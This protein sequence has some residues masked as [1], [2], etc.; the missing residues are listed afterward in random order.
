MKKEALYQVAWHNYSPED[1]IRKLGS[2]KSG[3]SNTEVRKRKHIYGKNQISE[4]KK[5]L[6]ILKFLKQ[7]NNP[8]IYILLVAMII[9]LVFGHHIDAYV[10]FAVMMI[11]ATIGFVQEY[12]AEKAISALKKLIVSYAKVY[13]GGELL[14]IPAEELIPGDIITLEAGY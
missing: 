7:F 14:K 12:K 5:T 2:H 10:I 9:S 6:T 3:L 1:T 8:L 11:N 4:K 13:R